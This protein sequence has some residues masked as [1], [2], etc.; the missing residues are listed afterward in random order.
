[1]PQQRTA[2]AATRMH[3]VD[4]HLQHMEF[5]AQLARQQLTTLKALAQGRQIQP[6]TREHGIGLVALQ[7]LAS[8]LLDARQHAEFIGVRNAG[9]RTS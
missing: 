2:M 1:M 3:R 7:H 4:V 5:T 9:L 8:A 6:M